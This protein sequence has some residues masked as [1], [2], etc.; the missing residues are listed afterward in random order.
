MEDNR[1]IITK[2]EKLYIVEAG[3]GCYSIRCHGISVP[4]NVRK[5]RANMEK[6]GYTGTTIVNKSGTFFMI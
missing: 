1:I 4:K 5:I 6:G 2:D 3:D